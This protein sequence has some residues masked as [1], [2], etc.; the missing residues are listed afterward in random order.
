[1]SR[2]SDA[3]DVVLGAMALGVRAG[4]ASARVAVVPVALAARAPVVG[5]ALRGA[6]AQIA[7]DG[8][9]VRRD[10]LLQLDRAV[11]AVLAS[12]ELTMVVDR[13]ASGPLTGAV[14]R[15]LARNEVPQRFVA[16]LVASVDVDTALTAVLQHPQTRELVEALTTSPAFQ[17]I[18]TEALDSRLTVAV[19][20]RLLEGP[21]MQ[22]AMEHIAA[23]PELRRVITEQSAGMAEQTMDGVRRH[24]VTLDDAAERTV[25]GWLRRPRPQMS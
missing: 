4:S 10:A 14:A 24:S 18:L 21:V 6:A 5:S 3:A 12:P 1:M 19:T 13:V 23:S 15:A 11:D 16:E 9:D 20:D 7:G 17:E 22:H 25:R 2:R 8:R